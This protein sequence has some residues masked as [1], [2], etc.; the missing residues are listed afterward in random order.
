MSLRLF[1]AQSLDQIGLRVAAKKATQV[2]RDGIYDL[3]AREIPSE[4][5]DY[6]ENRTR[7][8]P[9]VGDSIAHRNDR[10]RPWIGRGPA[11][12]ESA[13]A[14]QTIGNP[15]GDGERQQIRTSASGE[16]L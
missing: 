8:F 13:R 10:F 14:A 2:P 12:A 1:I 5:G 6:G 15:A 11:R 4:D 9:E 7:Q 3:R 16:T